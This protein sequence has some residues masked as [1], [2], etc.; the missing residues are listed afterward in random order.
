MYQR[1]GVSGYPRFMYFND[2]VTTDPEEYTDGRDSGAFL[3]FAQRAVRKANRLA[4]AK[5]AQDA[6]GVEYSEASLKKL[7][8]RALRALLKKKGVDCAGCTEKHEFVKRVLETQDQPNTEVKQESSEED[9]EAGG[10]KKKKKRRR[11]VME[12]R[13]YQEAKKAADKGWDGEVDDDGT[14]VSKV[15]HVIDDNFDEEISKYTMGSASLPGGVIV[16][17]YAP[18]CGHCKAMKPEYIEA[19]QSLDAV[20]KLAAIDCTLSPNVC[21]KY[22]FS[23]KLQSKF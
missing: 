13:R 22:V 18:W 10:K 16:M 23:V 2:S 6:A 14:V 21:S 3:T 7:R 11:S 17:F 19:S 12:E 5:A 1:F 4:D 9:G 15:V 8:V 20:A